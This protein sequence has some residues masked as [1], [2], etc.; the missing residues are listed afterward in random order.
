MAVFP[1]LLAAAVFLSVATGCASVF[2]DYTSSAPTNASYGVQQGRGHVYLIRGLIG[3][4]FSRGLDTLAEKINRH[5]VPA[6]VHSSYSTGA[7]AE[8]II[9]NYRRE[10]GPIILI[11]HSTGGDAAI[12]IAQELRKANVPV[13]IIFGFDRRRSRGKCPTMSSYSSI[14]F[15]KPIRSAAV[16]LNRGGGF[17]GRLINVDLRE[18]SEI[19]H[20]TLD[21]SSK[22]HDVVVDEIVGFVAAARMQPGAGPNAAVSNFIPPYLSCLCRAAQRADSNLGHRH[23]G[24]RA[25]RREFSWGCRQLS[26]SGVAS[27]AGQQAQPQRALGG[28]QSAARS[29]AHVWRGWKRGR[30]FDVRALARRFASHDRHARRAVVAARRA[31]YECENLSGFRRP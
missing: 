10:P 23:S 18:H 31:V 7:L 5:G 3:E 12:D 1:R 16:S 9:Q 22:I 30:C 26:R 25:L 2:D 17:R 20:I 4:V 28:W 11:G 29:A 13:G 21:K 14:F 15:R 8:E 6:S 19:I 24:R 27:R